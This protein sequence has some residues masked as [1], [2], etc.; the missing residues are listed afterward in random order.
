MAELVQAD[1]GAKPHITIL[2]TT[3]R[4]PWAGHSCRHAIPEI[5]EAVAAQTRTIDRVAIVTNGGGPGILCTDACIDHKRNVGQP[6]AQKFQRIAIGNT[7][8]AANR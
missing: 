8:R 6:L 1:G 7:A 4:I 2:K 3:E 5:Y